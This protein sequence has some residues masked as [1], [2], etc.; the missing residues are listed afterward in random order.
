MGLEQPTDLPY[1]AE[2]LMTVRADQDNMN[3]G[4]SSMLTDTTTEGL[5]SLPGGRYSYSLRALLEGQPPI[6]E[7]NRSQI[8]RSLCASS[9]AW[10]Q[11]AKP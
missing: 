7:D 4:I 2:M 8:I 6:V 10:T 3:S 9:H 5:H 11:P 1:A